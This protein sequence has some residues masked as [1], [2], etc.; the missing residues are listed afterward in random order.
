MPLAKALAVAHLDHE[1]NDP[2]ADVDEEED[3]AEPEHAG[4]GAVE[5]GVLEADL[6]VVVGDA[7]DA[8][9][10]FTGAL[11]EGGEGCELDDGEG[12]LLG[13]KG[14]GGSLAVTGALG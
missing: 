5:E 10:G 9:I 6:V 12:N 14:E 8:A 11:P 1:G 2:G 3:G 7:V 13:E 4:G